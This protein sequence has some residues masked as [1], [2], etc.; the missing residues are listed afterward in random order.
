MLTSCSFVKLDKPLTTIEE[1]RILFHSR[2]SFTDSS[3]VANFEC[4]DFVSDAL[5]DYTIA[6]LNKAYLSIL[7]CSRE[8]VVNR[9]D[10]AIIDTI[11]TFSNHKNKI[12][13]YR[14][15]QDEFI[16]TFN[17]TDSTFKLTGNVKPGMSKEAFAKKFQIT[18]PLNSKVQLFNS[19]GNMRFMFYFENNRLQRINSYLYLD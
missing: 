3:L 4:E 14:A 19:E 13:I 18:E 6:F 5:N 11:Y 10:S 16:F 1:E 9:H 17:V 12:Q 15:K 2:Y 7:N 8:S